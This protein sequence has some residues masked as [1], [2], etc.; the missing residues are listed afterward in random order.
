MTGVQP[1]YWESQILRSVLDE[2]IARV[3]KDQKTIVIQQHNQRRQKCLGHLRHLAGT[4]SH[5]SMGAGEP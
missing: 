3:P 4:D 5:L 1:K 2:K